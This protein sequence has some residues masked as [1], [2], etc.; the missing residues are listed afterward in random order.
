MWGKYEEF[1]DEMHIMDMAMDSLSS[2]YVAHSK[3]SKK[4]IKRLLG[5]DSWFNATECLGNGFVDEIL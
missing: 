2:F 1:K 4:K 3:L 5:R